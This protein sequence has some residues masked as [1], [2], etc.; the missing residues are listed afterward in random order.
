[1]CLSINIFC[2]PYLGKLPKVLKRNKS[3]NP[4]LE[5]KDNAN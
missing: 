3:P 4:A 5:N 1:M 2:F